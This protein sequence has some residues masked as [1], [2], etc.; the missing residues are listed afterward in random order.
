M[1]RTTLVSGVLLTWASTTGTAAA[2]LSFT[3]AAGYTAGIVW[4]GADAA[5]FA[6]ENGNFYIYGAQ[7]IGGGQLQSVVR[8][9][10]GTST[11]EIARSP[12]YAADTYSAD[13][14]TVVNGDVYWAHVNG[15]PP[16]SYHAN[17]CKTS[18]D[19]GAWSTTTLLD[20]SAGINVFS[21]CTDGS[22]VFGVGL[23]NADSNVAFFLDS[24]GGYEVFAEI[25]GYSGGSG[26]D[27]AGNFFAGACDV[28]TFTPHMYEFSAQQVADR[29]SGAQSTPYAVGDAVG[30]H[31]VPGNVSA[32]MES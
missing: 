21:L 12:A 9:Y 1:R 29:L 8:M 16:Y 23:D 10:D 5:H 6:V 26:F 25:P 15:A 7:D 17:I 2:A 32:V 19:G 28:A 20:E 11:V 31:V 18:Y 3:P 24:A 14:I 4:S 30:D 22:N 27:S 13:A